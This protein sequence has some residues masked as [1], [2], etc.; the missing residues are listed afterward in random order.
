MK[1][2]DL[3]KLGVST[4]IRTACGALG[5]S[6]SS[7]YALAKADKFPC[8]VIRVGSRYVVPTAGLRELLGM[9]ETAGAA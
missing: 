5:I 8:R 2:E 7:G 6:P 3:N 1:Q 4:D 9:G